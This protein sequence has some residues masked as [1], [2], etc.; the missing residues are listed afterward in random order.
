MN[1]FFPLIFIS[2]ALC[3]MQV[4]NTSE[5]ISPNEKKIVREWAKRELSSDPGKLI[6]SKR[7]GLIMIYAPQNSELDYKPES[8]VN[9]QLWNELRLITA[10]RINGSKFSEEPAY[11]EQFVGT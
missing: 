5:S 10:G 11:L 3:A 8:E 7:F 4:R 2:S 1:Y 6:L 9:V